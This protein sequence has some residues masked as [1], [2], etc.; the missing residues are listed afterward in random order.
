MG[1]KK[2]KKRP[3]LYWSTAISELMDLEGWNQNYEWKVPRSPLILYSIWFSGHAIHKMGSTK[4]SHRKNKVARPFRRSQETNSRF[5]NAH[6]FENNEDSSILRHARES[7]V[8]SLE[9]SMISLWS[10]D[11]GASDKQLK[12]WTNVF[13]PKKGRKRKFM[14]LWLFWA[15]FPLIV[16]WGDSIQWIT[17]TS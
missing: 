8:N 11:Y 15:C 6:K 1:Q 4:K 3:L 13:S 12:N 2:K 14:V 9:A 17:T 7:S 5:L 10:I 16:L